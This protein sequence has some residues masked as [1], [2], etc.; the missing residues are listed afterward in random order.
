MRRI[1]IIVPVILSIAA[2][3][4]WVNRPQPI[5]VALVAVGHGKVESSVANT[6]AGSVEACQRTKLS[7]ISGGRIAFLG[8]KKGDHVKKGQVLLKLWNDDQQAQSHLAQTQVASSQQRIT[9]ICAIADNA[10]R[11]AARTAKLRARLAMVHV[12]TLSK[13][14]RA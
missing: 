10:M 8:V 1:F 9:E 2:T 12:L 4:W 5:A 11:E 3:F 6:R 13:R 14:R 7:P